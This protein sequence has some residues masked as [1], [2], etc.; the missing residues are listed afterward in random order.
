[1]DVTL[2][3][4]ES[5]APD[6]SSLKA[7][8]KLLHRAKWSALCRTANGDLI[9]GECQG[10][11][12]Q[13]YRMAVDTRDMGT[14]C[15]CPSRKFP[16][17][18]SLAL[19][20]WR[21]DEAE[22]FVDAQKP[23]WIDEWLARPRSSSS[24]SKETDLAPTK[25]G[26]DINATDE[27]PAK[28]SDSDS[29]AQAKQQARAQAQ[30]ERNREAREASILAGLDELDMWLTDQLDR[31]LGAF[32]QSMSEQCRTASRRLADAKAGGLASRVDA[33]PGRV[34]AVP[35]NERHHVM[36]EAFSDTHLLAQAYRRQDALS[37]GLRFDVRSM[38]GW[39]TSRADLL[40]DSEAPRI[41]GQWM[42]IAALI[43][44]QADKLVRFETWLVN[45]TDG[46]SA[47]LLD[48][49]PVS[50]ARGSGPTYA[51]GQVI[52]AELVF[53]PSSIP[54]SALI[55]SQE[56]VVA[57]PTQWP[58]A[59]QNL[60]QALGLFDERLAVNPWLPRQLLCCDNV[61]VAK[62]DDGGFW[63]ADCVDANVAVRLAA[64]GEVSTLLGLS[65]LEVYGLFD[66]RE[67]LALAAHT[68]LGVWW[69]NDI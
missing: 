65:L 59:N 69:T 21:A 15:S 18:H 20:W 47:V 43:E 49:V 50:A 22:L 29:E 39:T 8:R 3:R 31:G 12:A 13:P 61:F 44:T 63:L 67:W 24:Q 35:E 30:K 10:S 66:G 62:A 40:E 5:A 41:D 54:Q 64:R 48:Y 56:G 45:I 32:A 11:G 46:A 4:V 26:V 27:A 37:D 23:E 6:Q 9:W 25:P 7:A 14:K 55:A 34:L 57:E 36:V 53:Y 2:E 68:P 28:G 52:T 58:A 42:V 17:K 38:I 1:M 16:C 60:R 19:M 33:L 51:P